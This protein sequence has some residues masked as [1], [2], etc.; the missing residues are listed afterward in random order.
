MKERFRNI[1]FRFRTIAITVIALLFCPIT[2]N[3]Q[4]LKGIVVD[5]RTNEPII[6][7][8]VSVKTSNG[9]SGG[10]S[11]D[12]SGRFSL[13][14]KSVP[15]TIVA[16]YTGYNNE[17]I[18]IYEV[19]DDEIQ[20]DLTENF[21]ALQGVVVVGYGTQK[22]ENLTGSI[23]AVNVE[24]LKKGIGASVN[25]LL[26]GAIAGLQ[27]TP[28]S[29]QPGAGSTL[30]IRGGSSVQGGNEP[31]YVIDGFP[32]YN[33][34]S[35][36]G[37]FNIKETG[38][39]MGSPAHETTDPLSMLNPA[40]I[41]SVSILKDA[42]AT[43]IYGSR[44]ANGVIIITTKSGKNSDRAI[45]SYEGSIGWQKLNKKIDVL[46]ARDF[47]ELKNAA[48]YDDNPQGGKFQYKTQEQINSYGEG[49]DWQDEAY[50]NAIITN[51]QLS[52][53]GGNE[54]TRYAVSGGYY[55]QDGILKQTGF[56]RFSGRLNL[57]S[58]LSSKL[59]AGFNANASYGTTL[60]PPSGL[61][62]SLLQAP[63]TASI[64]ETDGSYVYQNPFE[65]VW[66][67]PIAALNE[68]ENKSRD[69]RLIA[70]GFGEYE[71]IENL[72]LKVLLGADFDSQKDYAYIPSTLYEGS[73]D[74]GNATVASLD[75]T[76][77]LNENTL[78]YSFAI[79]DVH[80]FDI[81]AGFT[82]QEYR[83]EILRAGSSN[84][85]SDASSYNSLG[86]GSVV[87]SPYSYSE[88]NTLL[89]VLGRINYVYDERHSLSL[90]I[91]RDGSSRFGKSKKW[92]TFPSIGY[93]WNIAN[94]S[95][96]EPLRKNISNLKLRLS[97]GVTGNQEIGN[98]QS[99][100]TISSTKYV[101][102]DNVVLGFSPDRIANDNLGW[103]STHQFDAGLDVSFLDNRISLSFDY[104]NKLT[105]DLLLNVSIPFTSGYNT[106]LQNFGKVQN[107]GLE[108]TVTT[109]NLTG[110]LQ[111]NT[112]LNFSLNR[113][114]IKELGDNA[115]YL[116][117]ST[118]GAYILE[119]G[120]PI[121][122]FYGVL[123]DGV[124]QQGEEATKGAYTA[125]QT[126][127][128]GDRLYK[129]LN[130]DSQYTNSDDRTIIG[131]AEPDF[132]FG[133][134]NNFSYK[135]FDLSFF[136]S[137]SV[138]NDLINVNRMRLSFYNGRTN[139]IQNAV[140]RWSVDNPNTTVSRAKI[141]AS[142]PFSDEFVE[143]GTY[144]KLKN[145]TLGY[146]F[147]KRLIKR[148]GI[149]SLR[150][151][152]SASNLLT[153]TNYKGYDPEVTSNEALYA[154]RDYGAYPSAKTYNFGVQLKF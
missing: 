11:T 24:E 119:E 7:A 65:T 145:I 22:R 149:G 6:G 64:Y 129:D 101:I 136:F 128:A 152:A 62:Y 80:K 19:T 39:Q 28:T 99:L 13:A 111:W 102:G 140:N 53:S 108:F 83:F 97:Y 153:I 70:S 123:S 36:S 87:A 27:V 147:H 81:L 23:A 43:A 50:R 69:F 30:R 3:A 66:S 121:G 88:K 130:N 122:S 16:S 1:F 94:E 138:G 98:Y 14:L 76:S 58:K 91:R 35:S 131:S 12:V 42:S 56:D 133:L 151:Y 8:V 26:D 5:S 82:Q 32:I 33:Q 47:S 141:E 139:A 109:H 104:Y 17:E 34:S 4:T 52:I 142:V 61:V 100:A 75:H 49:I 89:S 92:G 127:I 15:T 112:S 85:V 71:F 73:S 135:G 105:K 37:V 20:I 63:S 148:L 68:I 150:L 46:N 51:H 2:T 9:L 124:L 25:G 78:S 54:K 154:G 44:G 126:A 125:G 79:K 40:D 143:D 55:K 72:K 86:S 59:T 48:M 10:A 132:T 57:N 95:F 41:E 134:T 117:G 107:Q 96:F 21:N 38:S 93:S 115:S 18:S 146:S 113:N 116:Y 67:N 29:G 60:T 144:I 90:S 74:K 77:W 45:I 114:E 106:S 103:E 84:Y 137:G 120:H 118:F 110:K 31:L